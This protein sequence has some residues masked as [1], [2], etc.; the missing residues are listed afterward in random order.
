M[1]VFRVASGIFKIENDKYST[2]NGKRSSEKLLDATEQRNIT[3]MP[4]HIGMKLMV[5]NIKIVLS[6]ADATWS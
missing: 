1:Y 5:V 4:T 3:D 2:S 6:S